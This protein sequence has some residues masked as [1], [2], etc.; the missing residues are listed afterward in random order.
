MYGILKSV[1]YSVHILCM[2]NAVPVFGW[3]RVNMLGWERVSMHRQQA[4]GEAG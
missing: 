2:E 1:N 3:E 4:K